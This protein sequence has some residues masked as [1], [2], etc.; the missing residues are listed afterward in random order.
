MDREMRHKG[1]GKGMKKSKI[2]IIAAIIIAFAAYYGFRTQLAGPP[3]TKSI[4]ILIIG[5]AMGVVM[6]YY[7]L[8]IKPTGQERWVAFAALPLCG[9]YIRSSNTENVA[10]PMIVTLSLL[11]IITILRIFSNRIAQQKETN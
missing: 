1:A 10:F 7:T 11:I 5:V 3:N 6:L 8:A 2:R 9:I 4:Q